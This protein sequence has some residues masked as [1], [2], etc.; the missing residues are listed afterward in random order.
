MPYAL[1]ARCANAPTN[2]SVLSSLGSAIYGAK[3]FIRINLLVFGSGAAILPILPRPLRP[4]GVRLRPAGVR[5]QPAGLR[6]RF[7][8][9]L[10]LLLHLGLE[11]GLLLGSETAAFLPQ[12]PNIALIARS[13]AIHIHWL[14]AVSINSTI[15]PCLSWH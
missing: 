1:R 11:P 9:V 8:T 15:G 12:S 10:E 3:I 7:A 13:R 14:S 2:K 6:L 5:L 4:A